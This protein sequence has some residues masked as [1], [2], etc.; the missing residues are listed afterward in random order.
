MLHEEIVELVRGLCGRSVT[1]TL[2]SAEG[3]ILARWAGLLA[4]EELDAA[5]VADRL[6]PRVAGDPDVERR[7][8]VLREGGV[9]LFT[10]DGKPLV[11][12]SI[13]TAGAER[14]DPQGVRLRDSTGTVV[15]LVPA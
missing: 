8:R 5:A 1:A 6:E 3:E 13:D 4:E 7:V 11:I 14:I 9:A 2:L 10:V 15:E 12:D